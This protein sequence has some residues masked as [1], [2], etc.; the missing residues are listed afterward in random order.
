MNTHCPC[1]NGML[2]SIATGHPT[3]ACNDCGLLFSGAGMTM[4]QLQSKLDVRPDFN[5][6]EDQKMI[7]TLLSQGYLHVKKVAGYNWI[8]VLPQMYTCGLFYGLSE[9]GVRGRFCYPQIVDALTAC[10]DCSADD[11]IHEMSPPLDD[12]WF[13]HKGVGYDYQNEELQWI[14]SHM[15]LSVS[16]FNTRF[17]RAISGETFAG[18]QIVAQQLVARRDIFL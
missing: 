1:C 16:K 12:L 11:S 8:G 9:T 13:K 3:I 2:F 10:I 5:S 7:K 18:L 15:S 6:E 4:E 14:G 17:S